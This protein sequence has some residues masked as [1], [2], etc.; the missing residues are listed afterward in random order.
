MTLLRPLDYYGGAFA[1]Q[2][3][4]TIVWA[5][6]FAVY[7]LVLALT[8]E[9]TPDQVLWADPFLK[10]IPI[11]ISVWIVIVSSL[12]IGLYCLIRLGS[13]KALIDHTPGVQ[14][15]TGICAAMAIGLTIFAIVGDTLPDFVPSEESAKPG[16]LYGMAAGYGEEVLMRFTILP[17]VFY[18]MMKLIPNT[19]LRSRIL[20][21]AALAIAVATI[22]FLVMHE[23]GETDHMIVW[24]LVATRFMV[25]CFLMGTLTFL[26]GPG[27][28]IFMHA[29][30]H[31][32][33][34]TLF[35]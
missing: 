22:A 10:V 12:L 35:A 17:V 3:M 4:A 32:V 19:G 25:P 23:A 14:I 5:Q 15:L 13:F 16:Y 28:V 24:K 8:F 1:K 2:L 34:P 6:V 30:M 33:I 9:T 20:I 31:V 21:S 29:T 11:D 26:A 7:C 18:G 27:F